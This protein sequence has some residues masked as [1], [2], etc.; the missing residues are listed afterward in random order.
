MP[1]L[2]PLHPR[3]IAKKLKKLGF[4]WPI[5][6]WRHIHFVLWEKVIPLTVHGW[7][8]I[9]TDLISEIIKEIWISREERIN[10]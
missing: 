8:D 5:P 1:R 7:K 4:S 9:D 10:L 6:W 3:E 2:I